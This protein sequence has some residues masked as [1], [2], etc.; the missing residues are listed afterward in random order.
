MVRTVVRH[1]ERYLF[2]VACRL[3]CLLPL[4]S[5]RVLFLSDTRDELGGNLLYMFDRVPNSY[6]KIV[7][8][9]KT[10]RTKRTVKEIL[11]LAINLETS[12]YILLDDLSTSISMMKVRKHQK[13]VQTW[14]GAGAYKTFGFSRNDES[15]KNAK[16]STHRNYTHAIVSSEQIRWCYAEGFKMNVNDVYALGFARSD[17]FFDKDYYERKRAEIFK[18][19]PEFRDKK[20]ILFAPTYRG[21]DVAQAS[22]D[23]SKLDFEKLYKELHNEYVF[24]LKWHPANYNV[25]ETNNIQLYD[26]EKYPNFFYD[27]SRQRDI[28]DLL[29]ITDILVTD[30]SS[31]IF[32]YLLVN[33]PVVYYMYDRE[34]YNSERGLYFDLD[35]YLYGGVAI[36]MDELIEEIKSQDMFSEKREAFQNK[37]MK[38]CDGNSTNRIYEH[39]FEDK[40][41]H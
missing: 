29:L 36:N 22:Y 20:V 19:N 17:V 38:M 28:N 39:I 35:E 21:A 27:L 3:C 10:R 33:K 34:E 11:S 41:N 37:F 14:H 40:T 25:M 24:V 16:Y 15:D 2:V 9:R 23:Y 31:V 26:E 8:L 1:I 18:D 13:V 30:Y 12:K 6:E 32:D 4:N 7:I 5:K